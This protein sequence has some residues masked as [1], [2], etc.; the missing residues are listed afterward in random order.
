MKRPAAA[1][2]VKKMP[3]ASN[4]AAGGAACKRPAAALKM[5]AD[6]TSNHKVQKSSTWKLVHSRM[7]KAVRAAHFAKSGDDAKAKHVAKLACKKAKA[8]FMTGTL[9]P[10]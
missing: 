3:A 5:P 6:K 10:D 4:K 2:E 8:K 9:K 1:S 7:Y